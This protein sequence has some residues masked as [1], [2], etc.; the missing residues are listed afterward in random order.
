MPKRRSLHHRL[1]VAWRDTVLLCKEFRAPLLVC[2]AVMASGGAIY[3]LLSVVSGH[4]VGLVHATYH[5]LSL[6]FLQA[7][8]D[9][10]DQWYLQ[11]FYFVM[12]LIGIA[13][14][15][16]GLAD[17]GSLLFNRRNRGKE[18]EM[19]LAST[20]TN[21]VI[22]V[23]LGHLGFRVVKHLDELDQDVAVI[24][25]QPE[26]DLME[27]VKAM[28]IPVLQGDA[29]REQILTAAG[30]QVA[31]AIMLCTQNDSLNLQMALKARSLNPKI[32]VVIRIF[33]DDFAQHL[34]QHSGFKAFSAAG[35]AAPIFAAAAANIDVTSPLV[36]EGEALSLGR[37]AVGASSKLVGRSVADVERDCD[38][39][40]VLLIRGQDRDFHPD[41]ARVLAAGDHLAVL[42]KPTQMQRVANG[43]Q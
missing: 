29:T 17:F 30:V 35:M 40:V 26:D 23:G 18:W 10:P 22:L 32:E 8:L 9:W 24:E 39:S 42:G 21:H 3:D 11:G 14:L 12:P 1:E 41:G 15:A 20:L 36:V 33:D 16:Q 6:T 7:S 34:A 37:F 27:K 31:R 4:P 19:A 28:D 2:G 5:V 25:L 38:V 13:T 43:G